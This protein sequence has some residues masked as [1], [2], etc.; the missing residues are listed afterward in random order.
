M[1]KTVKVIIDRPLGSYHP[2]HKNIYYSVNYGYV[3]G[4]IA[5]D[6][7]EQDAYVLGIN[8]PIKEFTGEV[9]AIIHRNDD[10]EEKWVVV[11]QGMKITK[12]EIQEQVHFQEKYFES[13]IEMLI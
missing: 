9:V 3:P 7:E 13:L 2:K 6:G 11:P 1:N 12:A 8:K 5:P 10:I 4:I